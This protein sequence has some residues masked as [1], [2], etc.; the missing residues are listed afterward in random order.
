MGQLG[1]GAAALLAGVGGQLDAV[2][3][4]PLIAAMKAQRAALALVVRNIPDA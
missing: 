2:H 1:V 3:R 4:G